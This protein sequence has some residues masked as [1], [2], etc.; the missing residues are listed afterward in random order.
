MTFIFVSHAKLSSTSVC[1]SAITSG[2][3]YEVGAT[4]GAYFVDL[5]LDRTIGETDLSKKEQFIFDFF[6]I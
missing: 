1:C 5:E 6:E 2:T 3:G 4:T